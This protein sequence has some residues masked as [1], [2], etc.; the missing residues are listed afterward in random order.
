MSRSNSCDTMLNRLTQYALNKQRHIEVIKRK[1]KDKEEREC[2]QLFDDTHCGRKFKEFMC[3]NEKFV[4]RKYEHLCKMRLR[5]EMKE[6]EEMWYDKKQKL[7][8]SMSEIN[9]NVEGMLHAE[10]K[11]QVRLNKIKELQ[12]KKELSE[13]YFKPVINKNTEE[14]AGKYL[15]RISRNNNNNITQCSK[16]SKTKTEI[17]SSSLHNNKQYTIENVCDLSYTVNNYT[18]YINESD[19]NSSTN[20]NNNNNNI[21][22]DNVRIS[23]IRKH[24]HNQHN[25]KKH[26]I[27]TFANINYQNHPTPIKL[28]TK[29]QLKHLSTSLNSNLSSFN[30]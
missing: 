6:N 11:K 16:V 4:D 3:R 1:V 13:C 30:F 15:K 21:Y 9:K 2:K 27:S 18:Q 5:K 26:I 10:Y 22:F 8:R 23:S 29:R 7:K 19:I 25:T 24:N 12:M 17:Q 14:L 20:R 28:M